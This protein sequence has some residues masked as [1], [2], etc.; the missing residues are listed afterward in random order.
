ML[1]RGPSSGRWTWLPFQN[2]SRAVPGWGSP[3][4]FSHLISTDGRCLKRSL[5]NLK[6]RC[7]C[8][9]SLVQVR[10]LVSRWQGFQAGE[11]LLSIP[12]GFSVDP[13]RQGDRLVGTQAGSAP[14]S[15][16][17]TSVPV[18]IKKPYIR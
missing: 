14:R 1:D 11:G 2:G 15:L 13:Q 16:L 17:L 10:G 4:R 12:R 3:L 18:L 8:P 6:G 5:G 7:K 9:C